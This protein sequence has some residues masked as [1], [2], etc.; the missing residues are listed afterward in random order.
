MPWPEAVSRRSVTTETL[1]RFML[2]PCE[3]CSADTGCRTGFVSRVLLFSPVAFHQYAILVFTH[4]LLSPG[5][6][7]AVPLQ[8]WSGP[9]GSRK[10]RFPDFMTTA[11]ECGKV[12]SLTHRPH[13]SPENPPGT[14][15]C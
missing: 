15:F 5:K 6:G 9:E 4:M 13:L 14:D 1:L 7:K 8:A 3:I 2:S 10:L 11:Q 12:A